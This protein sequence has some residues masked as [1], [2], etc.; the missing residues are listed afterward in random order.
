MSEHTTDSIAS[1]TAEQPSSDLRGEERTTWISKQLE[2]G[3]GVGEFHAEQLKNETQGF[4]VGKFD[5]P[6]RINLSVSG[7]E[8]A[9]LDIYNAQDTSQH[10][11]VTLPKAFTILMRDRKDMLS[12]EDAVHEND[13]TTQQARAVLQHKFKEH[14]IHASDTTAD[15][16]FYLCTEAYWPLLT[17]GS[18]LVDTQSRG[19]KSGQT[20]R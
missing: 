9:R 2:S 18:P 6:Y 5:G 12:D 10:T 16:L 8:F 7:G 1:F 11:T 15:N 4:A 13:T 14:Q 17:R 19:E 3:L 20:G